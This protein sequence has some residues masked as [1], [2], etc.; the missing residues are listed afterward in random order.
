MLPWMDNT[1]RFQ[2]IPT[3]KKIKIIKNMLSDKNIL[4][5]RK[6]A[7]FA[8]SLITISVISLC[9]CA[10]NSTKRSAT[11]TGNDSYTEKTVNDNKGN[12]N[13]AP[14][15]KIK[16]IYAKGFSVKY[17]GNMKLVDISDPMKEKHTIYRFALAADP[18]KEEIP[19]GYTPI[20][21]P[22][23]RIICMTSLQLSDFIAIDCLNNIAGITSTRFLHNKKMQER[24]KNGKTKRIGMEGNFDNEIVLGINP[25]FIFISPFKRGGYDSMKEVNIP[26]VPHLGYKEPSPL[27]QAEWVKFVAL[28]INQEA[29]ANEVF[30]Q[31]EK[32]YNDLKALT[33]NVKHR[34]TVFSG[35]M[36]GSG[37]YTVGGKSFLAQIFMDAGADY[38]LKNNTE[39]GGLLLDFESIYD[40]AAN[41]DYWRIMNGYNGIFSYNALKEE[42]ARYADFKAFKNKCVI[43]CNQREKGFYEN[44]PTQPQLVLKDFIKIFHPEL[45]EESYKGT[46]YELLK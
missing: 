27:G 17:K 38:F 43:Y 44:S 15:T 3:I 7:M 29:K 16:T 25:D 20:R 40:K 18:A 42:D 36:H 31:I 8:L 1:K 13:S 45:I 4:Y 2:I 21:I 14:Y 37:W 32:Q 22:A 11:D 12:S 46:F 23:E 5:V 28:F 35:E 33:A 6:E 24:I 19:Q 9:G 10:N 41:A 26:L 34:P 30:S 39:S